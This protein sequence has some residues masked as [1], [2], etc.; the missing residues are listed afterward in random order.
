[1]KFYEAPDFQVMKFSVEDIMNASETGSDPGLD[2][3]ELPMN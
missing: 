2:E 1:M 3:N